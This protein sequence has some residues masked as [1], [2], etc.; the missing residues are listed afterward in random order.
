MKCIASTLYAAA[1]AA[2]GAA[3]EVPAANVQNREDNEEDEN[4]ARL[5]R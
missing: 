3:L 4:G 5:P 2:A 1:P